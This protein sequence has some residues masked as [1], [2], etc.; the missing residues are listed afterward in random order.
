M[1]CTVVSL[2]LLAVA[3]ACQSGDV[4][5]ADGAADVLAKELGDGPPGIYVLRSVAG[6][7]LPTVLVSH[8]WYHAVIAAD[9]FF[10]HADGTGA[11]STTKRVTQDPKDGEQISLERAA[12][13]YTV[14]NSRLTAEI[15]CFGLAICL[16]PP[17]YTG[18]LT[19]DAL[20]VDLALN[21]RVPMRY[22]KVAGPS[23]V[24]SVRITPTEPLTLAL[25]AT[26]TLT[27][28]ALDAQG[29]TLGGRAAGWTAL[30]PSVATVSAG[31]VVRTVAP[32]EGLVEAFIGGRAD[33]LVIRVGGRPD[34]LVVR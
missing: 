1:R 31:G 17:H 12:F 9:T 28:V 30:V 23:D 10:L 26:T 19:A 18:T 6:Q 13:R 25:G 20:E 24:A 8:E 33:T 16:A 29:R 22:A 11:A 5:T 2:A 3:G 15:P 4:I 34:S 32:G 27:A 21:Y 7:A 14:A